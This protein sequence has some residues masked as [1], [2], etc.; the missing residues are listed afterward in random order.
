MFRVCFEVLYHVVL[1][2]SGKAKKRKN[3][4]ILNIVIIFNFNAM[5]PSWAHAE[6]VLSSGLGII[7]FPAAQVDAHLIADGLRPGGS[8]SN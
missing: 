7:Y 5:A 6:I 2:L 4:I 3:I 8:P 1:F